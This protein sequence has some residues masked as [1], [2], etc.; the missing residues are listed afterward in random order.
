M[1]KLITT[2]GLTLYAMIAMPIPASATVAAPACPLQGDYVIAMTDARLLGWN[3]ER[4]HLG[5]FPAAIPAGSYQL[6][7]AS[8]DEH[9]AKPDQWWSFPPPGAEILLPARR[10]R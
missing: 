8:Y 2:I 1:R 10:D 9:S 4:S 3:E 6:S 5:P 7:V